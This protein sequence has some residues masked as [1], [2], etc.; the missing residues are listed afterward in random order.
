MRHVLL[1]GISAQ[2]VSACDRVDCGLATVMTAT[3]SFIA[4]GTSHGFVL[5]FDGTQVGKETHV[6]QILSLI[7]LLGDEMVPR[8]S[9]LRT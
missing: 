2:L 8:W 5:V 4:I 1:K 6:F 7:E 9:Q 3:G